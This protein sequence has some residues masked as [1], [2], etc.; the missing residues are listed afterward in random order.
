M[1]ILEQL[2]DDA[3]DPYNSE[4]KTLID[5]VLHNHSAEELQKALAKVL[6]HR[7]SYFPDNFIRVVDQIDSVLCRAY[8]HLLAYDPQCQ[9]SV[10]TWLLSQGSQESTPHLVH[11]LTQSTDE[12]ARYFAGEDLEVWG[13]RSALPALFHAEQHDMGCDYEE[14]PIRS[15]ARK[16]IRAIQARHPASEDSMEHNFLVANLQCPRCTIHAEMRANFHL[17]YLQGFHYLVGDY[18]QWEAP[19]HTWSTLQIQ[20]N[21]V[22]PSCSETVLIKIFLE[23]DKF[24]AVE[25]V[26]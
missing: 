2:I 23:Q 17:G 25:V 15:I 24:T 22:C 20:G 13:D 5:Q 12:S 14:R 10:C 4:A 21:A 1:N 9:F 7:D 26:C 3:L 19:Q 18:I 8:L 16:A 11:V 6:R